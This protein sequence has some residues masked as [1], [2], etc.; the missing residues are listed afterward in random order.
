MI[1]NATREHWESLTDSR[2]PK[3]VRVRRD[4]RR[5]RRHETGR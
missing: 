3:R 1:V 5:G 4:I 2:R